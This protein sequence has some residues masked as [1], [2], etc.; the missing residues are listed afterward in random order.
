[1]SVS[2]ERVDF[3]ESR[4]RRRW[5]MRQHEELVAYLLIAPWIIGFVVFISGPMLASFGLSLFETNMFRWRFAGL[6]NYQTLA[7]FDTTRSLFWVSL[8]NTAYYVFLSVPLTM[9]V[10]FTI[11][12]LLN[13]E[14]HGRSAYRVIYYLPA[15]IPSIA[16]SMVWLYL[17]EPEYGIIN[18]LL[19]LVGIEGLRWLSDPR[20][21]KLVFVVMSVWGAG[22]NMLIFL[23]GLQGIPTQLYEAATLDGASA[24]RQLRHITLPMLSPTL[25]FVLITNLIF[26]FQM[27]TD[28]YVMTGGSGGPA[29]ST[30][31]YVLHLYLV[32]FRQFRL[33]YAS[34]LAWVL[35]LILLALTLLIFRSSSLWVYYETEVGGGRS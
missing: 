24:W 33:G 2:T 27:F 6:E 16:A 25:F 22:G 26:S 14:I 11:A 20:T 21:A 35:F 32:A 1:M 19:S 7:T 23:A 12:L 9:V 5:G 17:F 15:I 34:A 29:N 18:W 4:V 28:A 3:G 31:M 13:Q 10:G 8:Y 30:M